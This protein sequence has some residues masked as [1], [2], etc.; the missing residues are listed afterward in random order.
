M[1]TERRAAE[2]RDSRD[3]EAKLE[4]HLQ[5]LR[6]SQVAAGFEAPVAAWGASTW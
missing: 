3:R 5:K 6:P 2:Q 1:K 4:Y